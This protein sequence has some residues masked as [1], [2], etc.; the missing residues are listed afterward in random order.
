MPEFSNFTPGFFRSLIRMKRSAFFIKF[1]Q[2]VVLISEVKCAFS[3]Y[4][5]CPSLKNSIA[6]NRP[7]SVTVTEFGAVGDGV[8][9]N[10]KAFENALFYLNS[11]ADKGGAQLF[12]PAGRWLT[13]S[14]VLTSHLTLSLDNDAVI[15]GSNDP[16]HWPLIDPLPSYGRGRE[17]PGQRHQSL[18]YG[19]NLT[20]VVITGN[21]G[22]IDGRGS[23]WRDSFKNK[24]LNRMRLHLIKFMYTTEIVGCWLLLFYT[25]TVSDTE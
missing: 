11:F 25:A 23:F 16:S 24:T 6:K 1:L 14:I 19:Y 2:I 7:H 13:G 5:N 4:Y 9:L 8:T 20:D 12:V 3:Q 15:I 18:I 22:T 10:T 17:L 21:N